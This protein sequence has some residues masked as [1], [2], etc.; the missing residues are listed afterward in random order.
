MLTR[1]NGGWYTFFMGKKP[2]PHKIKALALDLDGTTLLPDT[3]LGERTAKILKTLI[4]RGIQI[5][6]TTGRAPQACEIYL[7]AIGAQ[8]AMVFFNGAIVADIPSD[9][10]IHMS[11]LDKDI[12][13]FG[14]D[15]ARKNNYFY[16]A[17]LPAG[18]S[19]HTGKADLSIKRE[20]LLIEK[21]RRESENYRARTGITPVTVDIKKVTA[22]PDLKG[23]IKSMFV[24]D[25]VYHDAIKKKFIDKFAGRISVMRSSPTLLEISNSGVSKGEGLKIAMKKRGL[26]PCEVIAFGDEENDLSMYGVAGFF[27][28]PANGKDNVRAVA[29]VVF[30]SCAQEGLAVYLEEL[31]GS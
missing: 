2:D 7:N 8:G 29:D 31:F 26:N 28:A 25:E 3:T 19:P 18:I 6:I 4:S 16:Q 23:F 15:I 5:I 10:I 27:A 17:Y 11:L 12:V 20:Q 14:L 1:I 24:C 21:M 9:E 30:G 22:L 13:G